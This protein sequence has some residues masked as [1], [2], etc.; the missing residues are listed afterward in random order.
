MGPQGI[1][2]KNQAYSPLLGCY[3]RY[4]PISNIDVA[5]GQGN[6]PGY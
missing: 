5:A 1:I 3:V 2:L 4:L 6:K